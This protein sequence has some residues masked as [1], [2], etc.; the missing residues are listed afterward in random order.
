[1]D[2]ENKFEK[3]EVKNNNKGKNKGLIFVIIILIIIICILTGY[4]LYDKDIIFTNKKENKSNTTE[5]IKENV[6]KDKEDDEEEENVTFSDSELQKYVNYLIPMS[7]GPSDKLYDIDHISSDNLSAR[8][9]IEYIGTYVY[10]KAKET[11]DYAYSVLSEDDVKNSVEEVYGPNTYARTTFNL[12]CGDYTFR[13]N[14]NAYYSHTGCVGAVAKDVK[15][16]IIDYKATRKKLEITTAYAFIDESSDNY[17][18]YK[19][20]E[21][22]TLIIDN[23]NNIINDLDSYIKNNKDKFNTLTYT[24]ES[25]NGKNY[26]FKELTNNR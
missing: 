18:I 7:I 13:E 16:T 11:S 5:N 8:E 23:A 19:D 1:M 2:E 24:F 17:K 14:E 20:Y 21:L 9:K 25:T 26:Y 12:S 4:I 15:N 10:S 3:I 6:K 22:N